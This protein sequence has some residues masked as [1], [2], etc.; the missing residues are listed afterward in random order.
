MIDPT[1]ATIGEAAPTGRPLPVPAPAGRARLR[2]TIGQY[3]DA[4]AKDANQDF[5]GA[6]VPDGDLLASKGIAAVIADGISTSALGAEAAETAVKSFLADY[7]CT[8]EAWSVRTS[9]ERVIAATN[10]WMHAQNRRGTRGPLSDEARERGLICTFSAL[11]LKS[12]TAHVF[13]VGDGRVARVGANGCEELTEPHRVDLGGGESYLARALGMGRNVEIDCLHLPVQPGDVFMLSTDGVHDALTDRAVAGIIASCDCLDDA[14]RAIARAALA[15]GSR[16]NL[17]VQLVRVD[18]LPEGE[19]GDLL[20]DDLALPPAPQLAPGQVFEGYAVLRQIHA[21]ARSHVYLARDTA[22]GRKVAIKVPSTEFAQDPAQ[23]RALLLEEWIARRIDNP[24]VARAA[25]AR[26]ARQLACSIMEYVEG[27]TLAQYMADHPRPDLATVRSIV[28]QIGAGL[29]AFHRREMLHRDLRPH[30][31]LIDGEGTVQLIDFGSTQ[32]AGLDDLAPRAIEDAAFAGTQQYS[33]PE[34][35]LG[36]AASRQSDIYSLGVI[37]YQLL[38]GRLPY[39]PRVA[40][41]TTR[42]AQRRLRYAP[43]SEANGDVPPWVDA[44][45]ACAVHPDP[46]RRYGE[47]S[48]FLFDLS[49]PNHRLAMPDATP[50]LRRRPERPWQALCLILGV[51]LALSLAAG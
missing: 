7:Y 36:A 48:E 4:G 20:G 14:A 42:S 26:G 13:H 32:V 37:A 47:L 17:T 8:S 21:G 6:L 43:A 41:A 23:R 25:P 39:G 31:V 28:R 2:V 5:H 49:H 51:L 22:D 24:H 19:I 12:R 27:Q 1:E 44:A 10:S 15:A 30:N 11:V 45:L 35:Y 46:A 50:F 40:T 18:S 29:Q 16:D 33:A 38:T 34:H 3:S 9:A